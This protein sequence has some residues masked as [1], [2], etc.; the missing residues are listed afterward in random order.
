MKRISLSVHVVD[1]GVETLWRA[2]S[3]RYGVSAYGRTVAEAKQRL[4]RVTWVEIRNILAAAR[5]AEV[6]IFPRV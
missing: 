6:D 3:S 4:F 1:C 5:I 2:Y